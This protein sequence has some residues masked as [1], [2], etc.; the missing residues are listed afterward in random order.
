MHGS[1]R[2]AGRAWFLGVEERSK[3]R[4]LV[5]GRGEIREHVRNRLLENRNGEFAASDSSLV[6]SAEP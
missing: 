5:A 6:R 3:A 4:T 2:S 1:F